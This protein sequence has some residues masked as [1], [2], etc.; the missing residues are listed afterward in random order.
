LTAVT[1][2]ATGLGLAACSVMPTDVHTYEIGDDVNQLRVQDPAG[3]VEVTADSGTVRVTETI[4]YS[5]SD[6]RPRTSHTTDGGTLRLTNGGCR[7]HVHV[8]AVDYQVHVP[9]ATSVDITNSA[10]LV[11]LTRMAGDL[12][13]TSDAGDVEGTGLSSAHATVRDHAGHI[14]LRYAAAPAQVTVTNDA[15]AI[16]VRVPK[17][18]TYAV[19]A[20]T[21]AGKTSVSVPRD[22]AATRK[23]TAHSDAG[24][25]TIGT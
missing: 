20:S 23:I 4:R 11:R 16:E 18:G 5:D 7:G 1:L 10:G 9:A 8:C 6:D 19:D 13:I 17:D 25:V 15:G 12:N 14:S 24:K 21:D 2:I 3:K 22:P